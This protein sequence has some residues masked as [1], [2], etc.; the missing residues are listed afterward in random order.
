MNKLKEIFKVGLVIAD[1]DEYVHIEEM[2]SDR[3]ERRNIASLYGHIFNIETAT[4]TIEVHSVCSGI[5]KVNAA[6][7]GA[8][9]AKDCDLI[10]S[11]GLSGGFSD[12]GKL[13]LV[14]G[15]KF[16]EIGRAHV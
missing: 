5:G 12:A 9:L 4:K 2:F 3:L 1:I 13:D 16:I 6:S 15:T 7:A 14:V 10:I 8:L 11:A